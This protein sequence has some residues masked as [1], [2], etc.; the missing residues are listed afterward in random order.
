MKITS[1]EKALLIF[2]VATLLVG[3][4]YYFIVDIN[5]A[6]IFELETD[7]MI[8]KQQ[9]ADVRAIEEIQE[10][11]NTQFEI[12]NEEIKRNLDG[13]IINSNQE[14]IILL[15]R[16]FLG[17]FRDQNN[18]V[19]YQETRQMEEGA[20][21]SS[22]Y[23]LGIDFTGTYEELVVL[24]NR[25]WDYPKALAI[26]TLSMSKTETEGGE[27]EISA[28]INVH[29]Y[30]LYLRENQ[31]QNLY[32]WTLLGITEER[33]PFN[34]IPDPMAS[35]SHTY[36]GDAIDGE[37]TYQPMY[38]RD[39]EGH[40]AQ[41]E[42]ESYNLMDYVYGIDNDF[43]GPDQPI[44]KSQFVVMLDRILKWP[45]PVDALDLSIYEGFENL[46]G[47]EYEYKRALFK[48]YI[49]GNSFESLG[50]DE[51]LTQSQMES[52]FRESLNPEFSWTLVMGLI[53]DMGIE[54]QGFVLDDNREV[55]RAEA[56]FAL[57]HFRVE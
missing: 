53:D 40:W 45:L 10:S 21:D 36:L 31:Q 2:L 42:I 6:R 38:F 50:P 16:E 17:D 57:T 28:A 35:S 5:D 48:G 29:F 11:F 49:A 13:I 52:I 51:T 34:E 20:L 9:L 44:T 4:Y 12:V 54:A 55:T 26:D 30:N 8:K 18:T 25:F 47:F 56:V 24:L 41:D 3:G 33:N 23:T 7:L 22:F 1:R 43:F 32:K 37:S 19:N 14:E 46:E 27:M 39:I 15:A